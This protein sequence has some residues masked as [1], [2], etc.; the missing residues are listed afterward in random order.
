[1]NSVARDLAT[2]SAAIE[3]MVTDGAPPPASWLADLA[4]SLAVM[5]HEIESFMARLE[6]PDHLRAPNPAASADVIVLAE[7][8]ARR[9]GP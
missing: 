7:V 1:M 6:V 5:S 9:G 4:I 8:L 2:L 3:A